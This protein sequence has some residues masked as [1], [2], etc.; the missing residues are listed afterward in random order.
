[1]VSIDIFTYKN[2]PLLVNT[3]LQSFRGSFIGGSYVVD[4]ETANDIDIVINE[5]AFSDELAIS[6]GF[7]TLKAGD[8]KY[9]NID[10]ERLKNVYEGHD[11]GVKI[12][13]LVIGS[14]F[15]PAYVGAVYRMSQEPNFFTER[16]ARVDLHKRLCAV[17][18]E[19]A[20]GKPL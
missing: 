6:L 13:L 18:K 10:F 9:D 17:A 19:I 5:L 7:Y 1:M 15:W 8:S 14:V 12:N 16:A 3:V 20:Q 4:P 2:L 11:N